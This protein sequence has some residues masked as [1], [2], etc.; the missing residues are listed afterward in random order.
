MG[1]LSNRKLHTVSSLGTFL[2]TKPRYGFCFIGT[3]TRHYREHQKGKE[4]STNP[5]AS[6][7]AWTRGLAFR[8]KLDGTPQLGAFANALEQSCIEVIDK[9]GV[10]TKDLAIAIHGV[11]GYALHLTAIVEDEVD[12]SMVLTEPSAS[13]GSLQLNT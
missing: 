6:I 1:R 10:M 7:F 2:Q 4:T 11:K 13:T 12:R 8:G 3:V 5:V 9:D